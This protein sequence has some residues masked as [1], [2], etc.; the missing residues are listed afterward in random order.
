M[1][2]M[3]SNS[4]VSLHPD[5]GQRF[6][7]AFSAVRRKLC[8]VL[9]F[10]SK[11][12]RAFCNLA[13]IL[14]NCSVLPF[15][16]TPACSKTTGQ[17]SGAGGDSSGLWGT[18][19]PWLPE[20]FPSFDSREITPERD[21]V[22][23]PQLKAVPSSKGFSAL[24]PSPGW[25]RVKGGGGAALDPHGFCTSIPI[26]FNSSVECCDL[27]GTVLCVLSAPNPAARAQEPPMGTPC[28]NCPAVPHPAP[29]ALPGQTPF[30]ACFIYKEKHSSPSSSMHVERHRAAQPSR[31][32]SSILR[33]LRC[34]KRSRT[35]GNAAF[36]SPN[37]AAS[38]QRWGLWHCAGCHPARNGMSDEIRSV[39]AEAEGERRGQKQGGTQ[40]VSNAAA[41]SPAARGALCLCA[42]G[43]LFLV[44][45]LSPVLL[46]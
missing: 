34:V 20:C 37:H 25:E 42:A 35:P 16:P 18:K 9:C 36:R 39:C 45:S 7:F 33:G 5:W 43:K 46:H 4:R 32:C 28:P 8:S 13:E 11:P 19:R 27:M 23:Q 22:Q 41:W 10:L 1:V 31:R 6:S 14:S 12:R 30:S 15:P 26:G 44:V 40:A 38:A 29:W 2:P 17:R 24:L 21:A 3:P